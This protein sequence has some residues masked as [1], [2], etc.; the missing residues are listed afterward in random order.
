MW[1]IIVWTDSMIVLS[2]LGTSASKWK[3]FVANR[4]PQMQELT[5]GCEWRHVASTSNPADLISRGRNPETLKNC[6]LWWLGPEWLNQDQR[7]W[8]N[9]QLVRHAVP[10]IEQLQEV[11]TV[12]VMFQCS[13]AVFIT[14][15]SMLSR[16]QRVATMEIISRQFKPPIH[17]LVTLLVK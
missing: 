15:F 4:V 16:L 8:S 7:Q 2:W 12:K 6:R 5:A 3:T 13:P 10:P 9:T 14:T 17:T 1:S 11:T